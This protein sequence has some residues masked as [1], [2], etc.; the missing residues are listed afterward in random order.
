[1]LAIDML[2]YAAKGYAEDAQ[3]NGQ[4]PYASAMEMI[5]LIANEN[6]LEISADDIDQLAKD[7]FDQLPE[8][9]MKLAS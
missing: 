7:A 2:Y 9:E 5:T 8:S 4:D 6:K 3:E 1:M